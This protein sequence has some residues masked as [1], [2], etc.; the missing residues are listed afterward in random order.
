M[1][2]SNFDFLQGVNDTLYAIALSAERNLHQDPHT[3]L[4]K[5]RLLSEEIVGFI[6]ELVKL[7]PNLSTFD[8]LKELGNRGFLDDERLTI[9]HALRKHGNKAAHGYY[10]N[11]VAAGHALEISHKAATIY[12]RVKTGE[13]NFQPAKYVPPVEEQTAELVEQSKK[14]IARLKEVIKQLEAQQSVELALP[15]P[16]F[17]SLVG[18]KQ[19]LSVLEAND[20]MSVEKAKARIRELE[21][22]L[23]E[24]SQEQPTNVDEAEEAKT[25][26]QRVE[27]LKNSRFDLTEEQTRFIIDQQLR[28][29]GW[30]AD[31]VVLDYRKGVRP[32]KGRNM[33][34][35]E[36]E[37]QGQKHRADY[38]LFVGLIPIAAV[39]AKRKRINV[40]GAIAQAERYS[41]EFDP[42]SIVDLEDEIKPAW[43]EAGH[44]ES[45][46]GCEGEANY[47]L[48]F[49]FACNGKPFLRQMQEQSGTWFR[50]CRLASNAK[51]AC[52]S[53]MSPAG[54]LDLLHRD[55]H[56]AQQEMV[57]E[58]F[59]YLGLRPY[60]KKAVI[61]VEEALAQNK[62]ESLL[63]MA[64]GTGKTRTIIG[65]LYRFLKTERFKR[66][67]FLVDRSALGD[68][69]TE[70]FDETPLE[71][72][73][74]LSKI[75]DI[76]EMS[77]KLPEAETRVHVAT[78]QAMVKRL[79]E[80]KDSDNDNA[81]ILPVD[82]YDCI[83]VDEAHRGYTL[84]QE[85][86]E[87]ELVARD[88]NLYRSSYRRVLD[89]FDAVKIGLTATPAAH[90]AEIFGHPVYTYSYREA[91]A[92]DYLIDHET[93][94]TYKTRLNQAGIK[95]NQGEQV[96][97]VD[98][99]SG[100]VNSVEL[101]D[102]LDFH[103]ENF[104]R[105][106]INENFDRTVCEALAE[107]IDPTSQEK[108]MIFCVTDQHADRVERLLVEA[109]QKV[110]G[111]DIPAHAVQKITGSTDKVKQAIRK[112]KNETFPNVAITV[113]LLTTGIDVP[114]ICN[115]VFMRRVKSRILYE[116]MLGRAT[117]RCDEIGK[118]VFRIFDPVDL[119]ASLEQVNTMKPVVK[120]PN[121]T[122]EQLI[123]EVSDER[124]LDLAG[125][126]E[127]RS[128]AE[129][130][131]DEL[132]QKVMRVM[133]KAQTRAEKDPILKQELES[134]EQEWG[135]PADKIHQQL[136][137]AGP[138]QAAQ[139]LKQHSSLAKRVES[140]RGMLNGGEKY[141]ISD[142]E[143]EFI[144][145]EQNFSAY[146]KP[147]DYLTAFERFIK[148]NLNSNAALNA[149]VSKPK[150]LTRA[151]LKEIR[152][153]LDNQDFKEADLQSAWKKTTNRDIAASIVGHIRR[154]ALG[155]ALI[156][157]ERRIDMAMDS[158][159]AMHS[160][161]KPQLKWLDR[162]AKQLKKEV[163]LQT[164]DIN[165]SFAQDGG[166]MG[167]DKRLNGQLEQ[168]L[169]AL[170][171]HIWQ[172]QG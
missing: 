161:T 16:Q 73:R 134:I 4:F 151:Q 34:I 37:M 93:P 155:E 146:S 42:Q 162:I 30:E 109:L 164:D 137:Q 25:L 116:Q 36:W 75:Y 84:D 33:A 113:D 48:P 122:I 171:E 50:D 57:V 60:Q 152:I 64:T 39:E 139:M 118:T 46:Q 136:H 31:S 114:K 14:E 135:C 70:A 35:A 121:I 69:A 133:R 68:Q 131:L 123:D 12:Y 65:L 124:N 105:T 168:V 10:N 143:D 94:I 56:K 112:F 9:F 156:P 22:Q 145:R 82:Q 72:K 23:R 157:Y 153:L 115:L 19:Q 83:I 130:A 129:D 138:K 61:A 26:K 40:S 126:E 120:R 141:I 55:H 5:V 8:Q 92:E 170:N 81:V 52:Q 79:F 87:A 132:S 150:E 51:R 85:L 76:K 86:G 17:K 100:E 45:W 154:A 66:I 142:H 128:F 108:T 20:S 54:L 104:N 74:R 78:V 77:D 49:V 147:E 117:R 44:S 167:L 67:L 148:D 96:D 27:I 169:A 32:E 88:P 165:R 140:V 107:D 13:A 102:E 149:V 166:S 29:A 11:P 80:D 103:V 111:D 15:H 28:D 110:H 1:A 159:Y 99:L 91:V 18:F 41:R 47:K 21:T 24:R 7:A 172:Q 71:Q 38:V 144:I 6:A 62:R 90:T 3:T 101:E 125:S 98:T 158:I 59:E 63:A 89:Y 119:Y 43:I 163:V 58:P 127:G 97:V 106:V 160:W 95:F 2:S 53:F